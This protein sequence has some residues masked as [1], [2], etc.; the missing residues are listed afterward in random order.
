MTT[1]PINRN[2]VFPYIIIFGSI[3]L[4]CSFSLIGNNSKSRLQNIAKD[5]NDYNVV[6]IDN[7]NR[8]L[9][10]NCGD[11]IIDSCRYIKYF[12]GTTRY[13]AY[14]NQNYEDYIFDAKTKKSFLA[15]VEYLI[16]EV[17]YLTELSQGPL[18]CYENKIFGLD[19]TIIQIADFGQPDVL[20]SLNSKF[21]YLTT[22][23]GL[24]RINYYNLKNNRELYL[25]SNQRVHI[26]MTIDIPDHLI[27]FRPTEI[28]IS[29]PVIHNN[30]LL[31]QN[32][33][34][35]LSENIYEELSIQKSEFNGVPF[36]G[37]Q[38]FIP[39]LSSTEQEVANYYANMILQ[40]FYELRYISEDSSKE[41][42]LSDYLASN[43]ELNLDGVF[44]S[45]WGGGFSAICV[46]LEE[47]ED[48]VTLN[49][50]VDS[51]F[52]G[53]S[54]DGACV[55]PVATFDKKSG[56]RVTIKDIVKEENFN[57]FIEQ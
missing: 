26:D 46:P 7:G 32:I 13:V 39:T 20:R 22:P 38:T 42:F 48:Y 11:L 52:G 19:N 21:L 54:G 24:G 18:F 50:S 35:W 1:Y 36:K 23:L 41:Y 37:M 25:D 56:K 47:T 6:S 33:L 29:I 9:T 3:L 8:F 17:N 4:Y 55:I 44:S 28:E 12:D 53:G 51:N 30:P 14:S 40:A 34:F 10:L 15:P 45:F 43:K 16:E 49:G 2:N 5:T 31:R 27:Y 57:D